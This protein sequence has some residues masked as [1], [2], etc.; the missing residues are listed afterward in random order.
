MVAQIRELSTGSNQW[1]A[2]NDFKN[3]VALCQSIPGATAI[4]TAAYVGL[5]VRGISG[6]LAAYIGFGLPAFIFMLILSVLYVQFKSLPKFTSLFNGLQVIVVAIIINATYS[7]GKDIANNYKNILIALL[8]ALSLWF[9][10]SPFVVIIVAGILGMTLLKVSAS[11]NIV[12]SET[13][14]T[15]WNAKQIIG[16][17]VTFLICFMG[18]Y[19]LSDI[20]FN[21]AV[22]MLKIDLFAF[23]GGFASLPLMLHE[24]VKFGKIDVCEK[25]RG[26][27]AEWHSFARNAGFMI[28]KNKTDKPH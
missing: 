17:I 24:I 14:E 26:K 27:V 21:L 16:L 11:S 10:V 1:I 6:A 8:A 25:L 18:L 4:Q 22:A 5:K 15:P 23:G 2:E 9:G 3:G 13:K 19:L 7:F 20:L 28:G 12:N